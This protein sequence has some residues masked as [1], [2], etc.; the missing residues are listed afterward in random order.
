MSRDDTKTY[1]CFVEQDGKFCGKVEGH[2]GEHKYYTE[3]ELRE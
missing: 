3:E 1:C 2:K